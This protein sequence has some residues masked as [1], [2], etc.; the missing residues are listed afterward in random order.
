[1]TSQMLSRRR[2]SDKLK[3]LLLK[4][5]VLVSTLLRPFTINMFIIRQRT[6]LEFEEESNSAKPVLKVVERLEN[7]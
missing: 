7:T 6:G 4:K 5:M 2:A 3:A 1:M